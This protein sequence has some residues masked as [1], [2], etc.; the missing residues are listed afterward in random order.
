MI[1]DSCRELGTPDPEYTVLGNGITVKFTA[2]E[3]A[4]VPDAKASNRQ[5]GGLDGGLAERIIALIQL[6]LA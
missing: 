6:G 5:S 1:C 2:L 4:I 3:S